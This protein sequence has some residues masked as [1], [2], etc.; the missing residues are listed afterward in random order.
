[1]SLMMVVLLLGSC[2]TR[3]IRRANRASKK[4]TEL[5]QKYPELLVKDT[6]WAT[7]TYEVEKKVIDTVFQFDRDTTYIG[8]VAY[9]SVLPPPFLN[10]YEEGV[11]VQLKRIDKGKDWIY[12]I[13]ATVEPKIIEV[14]V[15]VPVE[16]IKPIEY[17]PMPL[18]TWQKFIGVS[19]IILWI[20]LLFIATMI[21]VRMLKPL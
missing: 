18:K 3:E 15:E 1:M 17:K 4:L 20:I 21:I 10:Y 5:T 13:S 19:G 8:E 6:V 16:V 2:N 11:S 7:V 14:P 9:V 12:K